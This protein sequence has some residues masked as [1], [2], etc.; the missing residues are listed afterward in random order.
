V[1]VRELIEHLLRQASGAPVV[2]TV[3]G[4][5]RDL[6]VVTT[7]WLSQEHDPVAGRRVWSPH[8]DALGGGP[9][10]HLEHWPYG[11]DRY[12][13]I[14]MEQCPECHGAG[15]REYVEP[16]RAHH[17]VLVFPPELAAAVKA[18]GPELENDCE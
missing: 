11:P 7:R 15:C 8:N 1:T 12:P 16:A 6:D 2:L 13:V 5:R 14:T 3:D 18:S 17:D 4:V 10:V 9:V